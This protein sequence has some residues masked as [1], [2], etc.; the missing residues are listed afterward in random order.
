LVKVEVEPEII[1]QR[2]NIEHWDGCLGAGVYNAWLAME[3][4]IALAKNYGIGLVTLKNTNHWMRGGT[5]GWQAA[6]EGC[7]GI[8]TTNT[9]ANMP[10]WGGKDA[11]LG[12]NPLV[13]AIPRSQGQVVLDMAVSQYSYGALQEYEQSGRA[14][15]VPGGYDA[16]GNLT[17]DPA[18]I[19]HSQRVLPVGF[20]KGSGL[21]LVIDV[22]LASLSGGRTVKKITE[23]GKEKGLSQ[24]FLCIHQQS[25]HEQLIQEI[26]EYTKTSKPVKEGEHIAYP[27]ENTLAT[28]RENL[29]HGIPVNEDIWNQVLAL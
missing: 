4:A 20:W 27:G 13:I 5:Y 18:A 21:S 19:F 15:P 26:I 12:N 28:R 10:P 17:K 25:F 16:E 22:L 1:D 29:M 6:D 9:T 23:D 11:R 14:L 2:G 7:I 24:L 8:C 3:R